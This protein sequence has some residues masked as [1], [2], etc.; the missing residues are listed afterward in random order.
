MKKFNKGNIALASPEL[1]TIKYSLASSSIFIS[2][3]F[4]TI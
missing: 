2:I 1:D 4:K 3:S